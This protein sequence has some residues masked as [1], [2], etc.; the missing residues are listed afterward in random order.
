MA[1]TV[2]LAPTS[3]LAMVQMSEETLKQLTP[4]EIDEFSEAFMC[5]D[6]NGN[7]KISTKELGSAMRSLGQ[8]PTERVCN[9][10]VTI[11]YS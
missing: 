6:K 4:R 8:N 1:A 10:C 2:T 9:T 3:H 5:F 11:N 7:G